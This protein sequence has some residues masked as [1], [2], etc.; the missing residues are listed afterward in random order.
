MVNH[1]NRNKRWTPA[2]WRLFNKN[3]TVAVIADAKPA[4]HNEVISWTGFDASDFQ[5]QNVANARLIAAAPELYEAL[6][7]VA[8]YFAGEHAYDHPH[9]A[10]L[11]AA[12]AKARGEA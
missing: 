6:E 9:C 10:Q 12:L 2:P 3:G 1:P 11:R 4:P 5:K 8:P 7:A